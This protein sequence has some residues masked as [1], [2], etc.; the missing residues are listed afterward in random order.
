MKAGLDVGYEDTETR[1]VE[2]AY[3]GAPDQDGNRTAYELP[4]CVG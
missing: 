4:D 3:L 2:A 1:A